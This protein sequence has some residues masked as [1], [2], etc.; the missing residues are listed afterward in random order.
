MKCSVSILNCDGD[1]YMY[2]FGLSLF[3][4][5]RRL[6]DSY[7]KPRKVWEQEM[8]LSLTKRIYDQLKIGITKHIYDQLKI[9]IVSYPVLKSTWTIPL[10]NAEAMTNLKFQ[11]H[12]THL[13]GPSKWYTNHFMTWIGL[14]LRKPHTFGAGCQ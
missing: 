9:G 4:F 3:H 7:L 12:T 11:W 5:A 2:C 14:T 13:P 1:P 8:P 10:L 6:F